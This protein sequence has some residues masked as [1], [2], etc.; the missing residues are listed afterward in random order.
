M[1][2]IIQQQPKAD[3][4][5]RLHYYIS[6]ESE[7]YVSE[8][9]ITDS[10][11]QPIKLAYSQ[12]KPEEAEEDAFLE[13]DVKMYYNFKWNQYPKTLEI[14]QPIVYFKTPD[15]TYDYTIV[16]QDTFHFQ[17]FGIPVG[18]YPINSTKAP[19]NPPIDMQFTIETTELPT[20]V[21]IADR[22]ILSPNG[23]YEGFVIAITGVYH[24]QSERWYNEGESYLIL[25]FVKF[26]IGG[27]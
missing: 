26:T 15:D 4:I 5:A 27:E 16:P 17:I 12:P 7:L 20:E 23:K 19:D 13:M 3:I 2:Y 1:I 18:D 14:S 24:L 6:T 9:T 21:Q 10:I 25:P 8:Y 22:L 11:D